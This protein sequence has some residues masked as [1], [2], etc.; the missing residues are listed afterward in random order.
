MVRKYCY[1]C[2]ATVQPEGEGVWQCAGCGQR[3]YDNPKP[4]VE[5]ALFNEAGELLMT[6]RGRDPNAGKYDMPGG[7][8]DMHETAE[9]ALAREMQE[10]LGLTEDQ[11]TTPQYV[12]SFAVD[13]PWGKETYQNIVLEF[14]AQLL[15]GCSVHPDDDVED[16]Q[17]VAADAAG[18]LPMAWPSHQDIIGQVLR[19]RENPDKSQ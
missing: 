9:A 4:C 7:F 3:F 1:L 5:I 14:T 19:Y 15:P 2:G 11:Y 12:C 13:Y 6:K 17:W 10:E 8:I 16:V 18:D